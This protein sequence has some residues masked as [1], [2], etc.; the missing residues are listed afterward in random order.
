[1]TKKQKLLVIIMYHSVLDIMINSDGYELQNHGDFFYPV[2]CYYCDMSKT[3]VIWHWHKELELIFVERGIIKVGAGQTEKI[4]SEGDGCFINSEI[5][6]DVEQVE[7]QEGILK[8]IVF[9][10]DLIGNLNSIY[11]TKFLNPIIENKNLPFIFFDGK[12]DSEIVSFIRSAWESQATENFGYEFDVRNFLSKIILKLI[13]GGT[14]KIYSPTSKEIRDNER[15]KIMMNFIEKNFAE[16]LTLE[17]IAATIPISKAE[18][19][20]CFKRVTGNTPRKFLKDYRVL[21]AAE[22]IR[23]SKKNISDI[24]FDCGFTD[25]S[26]FSKSFREIFKISPTDYRQA[27]IFSN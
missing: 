15:V 14:G 6:H 9:H 12:K 20:L 11:R 24:A 22:K 8:S 25:M 13:E 16:N 27:K 19:I 23:S 10:S 5:L 18:C 21:L 2:G 1:M 7:S 3:K 4:L 17:Q 26:Y